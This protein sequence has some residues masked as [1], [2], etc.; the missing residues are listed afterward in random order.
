[1]EENAD[2]VADFLKAMANPLRLL[3][4]CKL[5]EGEKN[6]TELIEAT[7]IAQTSISQ[8]LKKLKD[9]GLVEYRRDH[10]TLFYRI[11]HPVANQIMAVLYE[12]FCNNKEK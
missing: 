9:E 3:I 5:A 7:A 6:V 12:Y 4:L 10:R 11:E 8:H 2:A 1:M